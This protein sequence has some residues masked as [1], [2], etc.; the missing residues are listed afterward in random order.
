[1]AI[2]RPL[3]GPGGRRRT[4]E[5]DHG[6]PFESPEP[7]DVAFTVPESVWD[8]EAAL[9]PDRPQVPER[10]VDAEDDPDTDDGGRA[11]HPSMWGSGPA[12][13]PLTVVRPEVPATLTAPEADEEP[14]V[15]AVTDAA[16]SARDTNTPDAWRAVASAADLVSE[17][18][19]SLE[20][21]AE[22][23]EAAADEHRA[24]RDAAALAQRAEGA[25]QVAARRADAAGR[26][27]RE[28]EAAV[29]VAR[30]A[31]SP[32]AWGEVRR[33]VMDRWAADA[34]DAAPGRPPDIGA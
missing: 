33:M 11:H 15:R 32:A 16:T 24:A 31:N 27:A 7:T 13:P 2:I 6:G 8:I 26:L 22:V 21:V 20:L 18:A 3:D 14:W 1:M 17:M 25:A 10:E 19:R 34:R 12:Q 29:S 28:I 30:R 23:V 9:R 4:A 5:L